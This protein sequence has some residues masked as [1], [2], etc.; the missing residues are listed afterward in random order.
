MVK[1][2]ALNEH[3]QEVQIRWKNNNFGSI[4]LFVNEVKQPVTIYSSKNSSMIYAVKE[5]KVLGSD[6][7]YNIGIF[8]KRILDSACHIK[9]Q[10]LEV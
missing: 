4:E 1:Y 5:G 8:K 9:F 2:V 3:N 6:K 10:K 7:I